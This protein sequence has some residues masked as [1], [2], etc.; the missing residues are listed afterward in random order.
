MTSFAIVWTQ[1]NQRCAI[2]SGL[3]NSNKTES[4]SHLRPRQGH[5][6]RKFPREI[7]AWWFIFSY[8]LVLGEPDQDEP[9]DAHPENAGQHQPEAEDQERSQAHVGGLPRLPDQLPSLLPGRRHR[10]V[11]THVGLVRDAHGIRVGVEPEVGLRHDL[12]R[13]GRLETRRYHVSSRLNEAILVSD[14]GLHVQS[15]LFNNF[16]CTVYRTSFLVR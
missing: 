5:K 15:D 10:H 8:L 2:P 16:Y 1:N 12:Y 4:I 11:Q 13:G 3:N 14:I 7:F 9:V 6:K